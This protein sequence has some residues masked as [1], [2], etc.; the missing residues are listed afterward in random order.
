MKTFMILSAAILGFS[1]LCY[2]FGAMIASMPTVVS[3]FVLLQLVNDG[4]FKSN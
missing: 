1:V 4:T 2:L 3:V